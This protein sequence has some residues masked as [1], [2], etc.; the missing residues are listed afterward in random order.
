MKAEKYHNSQ[1]Y[2]HTPFFEK[3]LKFIA[4]AMG[5]LS[6]DYGRTLVSEKHIAS[7]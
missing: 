6:R 7:F 2:A 4:N 3:P 5:V 1:K